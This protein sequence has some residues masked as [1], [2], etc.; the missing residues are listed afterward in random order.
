MI[1]PAS[2]QPATDER[3][4]NSQLT[5][6][7]TC[8]RKACIAYVHRIRP[9]TDAAALRF[10]KAWHDVL[11][12]RARNIP[13]AHNIHEVRIAYQAAKGTDEDRN[14]ALDYECQTICTMAILYDWRWSEMDSNITIE[15]SEEAFLVPII[16]PETGRS[17]RNYVFSG[18]ID[19][20]VRL[21]DGR[22]LLMENK[23]TSSDITPES[24]YWKRLRIDSQIDRYVLAGRHLGHDIHA[25]LYDVARKPS[26]RPATV[27]LTDADGI[28]IVLDQNGD[29]VRTKDGKG[30]R[31]T[32]DSA[33][34]YTV[35]TRPETPE[36]WG[37]RLHDHI[38]ADPDRY[39]ARRE[40]PKTG[41]ELAE[42]QRDLW[43]AAH[44]W[45]QSMSN[46]RF[47]KNSSACVGYGTCP[48]LN[49]CSTGWTPSADA[50]VPAGFVRI[51]DPHAELQVTA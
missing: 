37:I 28:K 42:A 44:L 31:Q 20:R 34:G 14:E 2:P 46:D 25:V 49:L 27:T 12:R 22:L 32:G 24:D 26:I 5:C 30:W 8:L 23:T 43:D 48:Y 41:I 50:P 35:I 36:E 15:A 16:N 19:R 7:A 21:D 38:A 3:L 4:T 51:P 6:A 40:I 29:R 17:D 33:L 18:K 13:L 47:P 10:G 39:F 1:L 9:D 45:H 11:D